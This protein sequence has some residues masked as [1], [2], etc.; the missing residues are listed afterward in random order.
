[1]QNI[2]D[3]NRKQARVKITDPYSGGSTLADTCPDVQS[4]AQNARARA[5]AAVVANGVEPA[6]PQPQQ[7]TASVWAL[8][9]SYPPVLP[10][11][12]VSAFFGGSLACLGA[13]H[14]AHNSCRA[15]CTGHSP[16]AHAYAPS[17]PRH[18]RAPLHVPY[19]TYWPMAISTHPKPRPQ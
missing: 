13:S 10:P 7:H 11:P 17:A 2:G 19:P 15:R 12:I 5:R 1:Q 18:R 6:L 14:M 8:Q 9:P 16:N 4:V 3:L